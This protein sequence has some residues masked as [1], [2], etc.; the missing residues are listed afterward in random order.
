MKQ[1]MTAPKAQKIHFFII[2]RANYSMNRAQYSVFGGK[3]TVRQAIF[4]L[5]TRRILQNP[6]LV[7]GYILEI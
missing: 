6:I 5:P 7:A 2:L 1:I 3:N 4:P